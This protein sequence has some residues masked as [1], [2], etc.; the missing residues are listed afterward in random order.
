[1]CSTSTC[2][3]TPRITYIESGA[4][5]A[6]A[7]RATRS[8]SAARSTRSRYRIS[9]GISATRFRAPRSRSLTSRPLRRPRPLSGGS[10]LPGRANRAAAVVPA[11]VAVV[12]VQVADGRAVRTVREEAVA[13]A[14]GAAHLLPRIRR[15]LCRGPTVTAETARPATMTGQILPRGLTLRVAGGAGAAAVVVVVVP[16][17][18]VLPSQARRDHPRDRGRDRATLAA[19]K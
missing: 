17:E 2:R 7:P 13:A 18:V 14:N 15:P 16:P 10:A 8:A 1:M 11:P 4:R 19:L 12:T 9:S 3:M 5:H 6:P